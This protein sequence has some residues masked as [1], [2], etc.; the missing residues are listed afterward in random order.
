[1]S[2]SLFNRRICNTYP[3]VIKTCDNAALTTT[4]K[5]M[6]DGVGNIV[7]MDIGTSTIC[8]GGTQDF[9][10]AT[11]IGIS[12]ATAGLIPGVGTN[13]MISNSN[14]GVLSTADGDC[15]IAIGNGAYNC[16]E[17]SINIGRGSTGLEVGVIGIGFGTSTTG[18]QS[19]G[20]GNSAASTG[21]CAIAI[22]EAAQAGGQDGIGIGRTSNARCSNTI[23][24]GALSDVLA[25]NGVAV[26]GSTCIS[27][28]ATFSTVYGTS[29]ASCSANGISIGRSAAIGTC[30]NNSIVIGRSAFVTTAAVTP[31]GACGSIAIG[32]GARVCDGAGASPSQ[33]GMAIGHSAVAS[34]Y[35]A[36]ALGRNARALNSSSLS[37]GLESEVTGTTGI[38]IGS[39]ACVA[40]NSAIAVGPI[41]DVLGNCSSAFGVSSYIASTAANSVAIGVNACISGNQN[42]IAIGVQSC[43][44]PAIACATALGGFSCATANCAVAL[45][46]SVTAARTG[47]VTSC[48]F[49]SCVQ[50]CGIIVKTPDGLNSYRIAVDNSGNLTTAL[51]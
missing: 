9:T 37:I 22:G 7:P 48:E 33:W 51:A 46:W 38:A 6:T 20:L 17:N 45:G 49:E 36:T 2:L 27:P 30:A 29:A 12:G 8:Y 43:I 44:T 41:A 28:D 50:G 23:S 18:R 1:M 19:I 40:G 25:S 39:S 10:G 24:I 42:N 32:D 14:L 13:S 26:G 16:C 34:C 15:S 31:S 4:P 11:V 5:P 3:G 47:V 35:F 21:T